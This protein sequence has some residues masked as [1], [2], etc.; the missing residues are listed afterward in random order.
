MEKAAVKRTC[1]H[2]KKGVSHHLP[3]RTRYRIAKGRR[4]QE[5]ATQIRDKVSTVPGVKVVEVNERTGSVFIHHEE[6]PD[7]LEALCTAFDAVADDLFEEAIELE[8]DMIPGFSVFAHLLKKKAAKVDAYVSQ[9]T[10]NLLDLKMLVPII[11]VGAGLVQVVKTKNWLE[12][13][14]AWVLFYYAYDTYLKF[15]PPGKPVSLTLSDE[16][17]NGVTKRARLT[18]Q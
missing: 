10:D 14:P 2:T 5:L 7:I 4:S 13:V 6:R 18:A 17:A 16:S 3:T 12:Q 1:A 8:G 15:H 11:F 9:R